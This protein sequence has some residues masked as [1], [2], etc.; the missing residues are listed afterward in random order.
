MREINFGNLFYRNGACRN[1]V[2]GQVWYC[3][4]KLWVDLDKFDVGA[5]ILYRIFE[6]I[7]AKN[8]EWWA[9]QK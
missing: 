2:G 5:K 7:D 9:D 6:C 3:L 1:N 8:L 4:S